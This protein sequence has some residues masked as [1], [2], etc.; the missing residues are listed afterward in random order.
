MKIFEYNDDLNDDFL[1]FLRSKMSQKQSKKE[2]EKNKKKK[3]SNSAYGNQENEILKKDHTYDANGNLLE[4]KQV[5]ADYLPNLAMQNT[6]V[7]LGQ[8]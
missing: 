1:D 8:N 3:F 6:R 7:G 5:K 4:V 2:P